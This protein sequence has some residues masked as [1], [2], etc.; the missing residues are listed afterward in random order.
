MSEYT[1]DLAEMID[2]LPVAYT[3]GATSYN[4][5]LA[6]I[7]TGNDLEEG[8]FLDDADAVMVGKKSDH[9]TVPSIGTKLTTDGKTFRITRITTTPGDSAEIRFHLVSAKR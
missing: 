6:T 4:G 7:D 2:D 9:T 1:D 3:I 8:G 5:T